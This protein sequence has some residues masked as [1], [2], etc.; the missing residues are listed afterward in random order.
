MKSVCCFWTN[1]LCAGFT[2]NAT[3][4]L[5]GENELGQLEAVSPTIQPS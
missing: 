2:F 1:F 4:V 3:D 5:M